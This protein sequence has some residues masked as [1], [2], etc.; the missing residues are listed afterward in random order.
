VTLMPRLAKPD[1]PRATW[2]VSLSLSSSTPAE[3]RSPL[4]SS[5]DVTCDG[6]LHTDLFSLL[7]TLSSDASTVGAVEA[8][9]AHVPLVG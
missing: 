1:S 8:A 5:V 7:S 9:V 6:L 4:A 2:N 3:S